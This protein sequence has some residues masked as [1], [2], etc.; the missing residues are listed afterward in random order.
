MVHLLIF[1]GIAKQ[2]KWEF[3]A[4]PLHSLHFLLFR[5]VA[6]GAGVAHL[7]PGQLGKT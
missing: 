4:P 5:R 1:L 3:R 7:G 2:D 6:F